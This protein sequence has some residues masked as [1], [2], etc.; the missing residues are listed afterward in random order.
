MLNINVFYIDREKKTDAKDEL[1]EFDFEM[2]PLCFSIPAESSLP[3]VH[4]QKKLWPLL[5]RMSR[6]KIIYWFFNRPYSCRWQLKQNAKFLTQ[7]QNSNNND[8]VICKTDVLL[9]IFVW[10]VFNTNLFLVTI[11]VE[12]TFAQNHNSERRFR[13]VTNNF[14]KNAL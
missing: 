14:V 13:S 12:I 1:P 5:K 9:F 4:T 11:S 10:R 7:K 8:K 2:K 3:T 6:V